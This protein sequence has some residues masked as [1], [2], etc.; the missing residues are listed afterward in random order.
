[1]KLFVFRRIALAVA[2]ACSFSARAQTTTGETPVYPDAGNPPA[3]IPVI[4]EDAVLLCIGMSQAND[5]CGGRRPQH[6]GGWRDQST[7][8][9]A[10]V[11]GGIDNW[12][13][14]LIIDD[15]D[16]YWDAVEQRITDAGYTNDDVQLIWGKN[17]T[18]SG[19]AQGGSGDVLTERTVLRDN[20]VLIQQQVADRFPNLR[21]GFH[22]SRAYGGFCELNS[23][24]FSFDSIFAIEGWD[25][26]AGAID[27]STIWHR[28]PYL[29]AD[30]TNPRSG[31]GLTWLEQDFIADGCHPEQSGIDKIA[32]MNEAFFAQLTYAPAGSAPPPAPPPP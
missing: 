22:S 28:G 29:W 11:N 26:E 19:V 10:I 3:G 18:R 4:D 2:L 8:P 1:M 14:R 30:G 32:A 23:E 25:N 7:L 24:P 17:A 31:D 12:D 21:A 5:E 6:T 9:V 20:L 15:P 16:T 13:V 27:S